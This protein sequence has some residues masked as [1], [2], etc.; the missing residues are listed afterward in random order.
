MEELNINSLLNRNEI[1]MK[2]IESLNHLKK[3]KKMY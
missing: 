1:E 3:T 2:L